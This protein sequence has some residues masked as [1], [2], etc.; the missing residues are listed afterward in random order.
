MEPATFFGFEQGRKYNDTSLNT[1]FDFTQDRKVNAQVSPSESARSTSVES[2]RR[3]NDTTRR[4]ARKFD[5]KAVFINPEN[6]TQTVEIKG[7]RN[8]ILNVLL[9]Y[10]SLGKETNTSPTIRVIPYELKMIGLTDFIKKDPTRY[11]GIY[12]SENLKAEHQKH[13]Q[14][15]ESNTTLTQNQKNIKTTTINYLIGMT[16][17][18]GF[19]KKEA[20]LQYLKEYVQ[21]ADIIAMPINLIPNSFIIDMSIITHAQYLL[22][23]KARKMYTI[24]DG[25]YDKTP[26]YT[27]LL[28][29]EMDFL[30]GMIKQIFGEEYQPYLYKVECPQ[31][32]VKDR[33][34]IWW[35]LLITYLYLIADPNTVD[36]NLLLKKVRRA[37]STEE[38]ITSLVN[39]FKVFVMDTV[40]PTLISE[41]ILRWDEYT[42]IKDSFVETVPS[43]GGKRRRMQTRRRKRV[44]TTTQR[45]KN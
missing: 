3:P 44:R 39:S 42:H 35:S 17:L 8:I 10:F 37:A 18:H 6:T 22:V 14:N 20:I 45:R 23:H 36:L 15:I 2:V 28:Y 30:S 26:I 40:I 33:N 19:P 32:V 21:G 12:S 13:I 25:Q 7:F 31:A 29:K 9:T 38:Q 16:Q 11:T 24:L 1:I 34:C 43:T 27:E 41:N 4:I 5:N